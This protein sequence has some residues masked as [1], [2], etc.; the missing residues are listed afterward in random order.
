MK[1]GAFLQYPLPENMELT[2]A[3]VILCNPFQW[4]F[5]QDFLL[6]A[7]NGSCAT[8]LVAKPEMPT[9]LWLF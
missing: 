5:Q 4:V 7:T 9:R 3:A 1:L 6:P 2:N 8:R